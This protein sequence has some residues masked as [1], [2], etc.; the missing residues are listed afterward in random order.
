MLKVLLVDDEEIIREGMS[1]GINWAELGFTV[2]AQAEDGGEALEQVEITRPDV[3]ITDIRMPFVDGLE[4]IARVKA[5]YPEIYIVIISG[6]DEFDYAQKAIKLGAYDYILKPIELDYLGEVLVKIRREVEEAQKKETEVRELKGKLSENLSLARE[7]LIREVI[8]GKKE[9]AQVRDERGEPDAIHRGRAYIVMLAQVDDYYLI[10]QNMEEAEIRELED[11][12]GKAVYRLNGEFPGIVAFINGSCQAI[13]CLW[14]AST[15]ELDAR[16]KDLCG[17]VR[18]MAG[19]EGLYSVTL[20]LGNPCSSVEGLAGCYREAAEAM[21]YK[22]VIGRGRNIWY[23]DIHRVP[24]EEAKPVDFHHDRELV[25]AIKLGDKKAIE[26]WLEALTTEIRSRGSNSYLYMQIVISN[27]Y[28]QALKALKEAGGSA[29]EV[30]TDPLAAYKKVLAHQT[31]EGM[32]GELAGLLASISDYI[33]IKRQ[34]RF[35]FIIEKAKEFI[36]ANYAN[37]ELSLE[38]LAGHVNMSACYFSV[39]FKQEVGETFID[40]L[41][42]A[43]IEKAG[44]LL[45]TTHY[46]SYEISYM[47]GYDNPTYFSTAFKKYTG[48]SPTEFRSSKIP[49]A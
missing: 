30:F 35:D 12:F 42:R 7:R 20:A 29:D 16:L 6:H 10:T 36:K 33:N 13:L 38:S 25:S 44:E 15:G 45:M 23:K 17:I 19:G 3:I 40:Y 9:T 32:A 24:R 43:R 14:D 11:A 39:I 5:K 34:G 22:F 49:K 1:R 28:M 46:K 26:A 47:V 18:D 4:F 27:L 48:T 2:A 8:G 21:N 31:I 41:T 37:N